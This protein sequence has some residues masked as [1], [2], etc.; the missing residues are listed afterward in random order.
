MIN[1]QNLLDS[2]ESLKNTRSKW[3]SSRSDIKKYVCPQSSMVSQNNIFS[4][5]PVCARMQL[6]SHLQSLLVNPASNWFSISLLDIDDETPESIAYC[7]DT[8]RQLN[9]IFNYPA[10][11]FF[12][13]VHEFFLT[14]T[15]FG[16]G[17]FYIEEDPKQA[18][19]TFFRN[20]PLEE[21]YFAENKY[22][23]VDSIYREFK[24]SMRVASNIWSKNVKL[25]ARAE[26]TPNEEI[27]IL[28]VVKPDDSRNNKDNQ[29]N[30][31]D[32]IYIALEDQEI[33]NESSYS[34]FPFLVCRWVKQE[35]EAYGYAPAHH[36]MPDIK[37]LNEYRQL[38]IKIKQKQ[39]NPALLVPRSGYFTP[40]DTAPGRINYY[41]GGIADKV[42]P[43]SNLE[44]IEPT[45]DEQAEC[46]D[47]I[48][49]A[50]F[51]DLFRMGK[52]HKEM[53][54]TEVDQRSEEQ[55]RLISP[56]VHRIE[57]EFL[58]PL[59]Q[60]LYKILVKYK[61]I[62]LGASKE[63]P[64]LNIEYVSPL[65]KNQKIHNIQGMQQILSFLGQ[66]NAAQLTPEIYDNLDWDMMLKLFAKSNDCPQEIFK[67]EKEV[68]RIRRLRQ[69]QSEQQQQM[70]MM[71]Q[72]ENRNME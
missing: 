24:I 49:K 67:S 43:L 68:A 8:Q 64:K 53:T 16:T 35:G 58:N 22:G 18:F 10:A 7:Q 60:N 33:L 50:Y 57:A 29:E 46:K 4:S 62:D 66:N 42:I 44:N 17:I 69:A 21:C 32:S 47:A 20:I 30:N 25:K 71:L 12:S 28:H 6:A 54:A 1:I 5:T 27:S 55:M 48:I 14:L 39:V 37:L 61:L 59:I 23:F 52:E 45:L 11:N 31:Y 41:E 2:F 38:G 19:C 70:Q 3:D 36:V 13:Q 51:V 72:A 9:K 56:I 15:A 34:Y 40:F 26:K 65:S 63:A